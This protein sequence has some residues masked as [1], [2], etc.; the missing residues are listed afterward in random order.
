MENGKTEAGRISN[1][2]RPTYLNEDSVRSC[3]MNSLR[4]QPQLPPGHPVEEEPEHAAGA[5][6]GQPD[7]EPAPAYELVAG[8]GHLV[9]GVLVDE[10]TGRIA[11]HA[12]PARGSVLGGLP[13]PRDGGL[14]GAVRVLARGRHCWKRMSCVMVGSNLTS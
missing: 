11:V 10:G 14:E 1:F 4:G 2:R 5:E 12:G 7:E 3:E 6:D 8:D 9:L 13:D